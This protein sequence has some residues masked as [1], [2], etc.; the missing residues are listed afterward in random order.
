M[1]GHGAD[2]P[3]SRGRRPAV[4]NLAD[5]LRYGLVAIGA[6]PSWTQFPMQSGN[7]AFPPAAPPMTD[8][9]NANPATLGNYL[10]GDALSRHQHDPGPPH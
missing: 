8:G 5:P 2:A 7:A 1:G 3:V 6:R 10:I 9:W 4:Q